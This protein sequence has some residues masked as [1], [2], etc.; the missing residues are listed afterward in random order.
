MQRSLQTETQTYFAFL[1]S[2]YEKIL[3]PHQVARM[4][5]RAQP[6]WADAMAIIQVL[7]AHATK[8][9]GNSSL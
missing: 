1:M 8:M 6:W 5:R 2:D 9:V 7:G 3:T 4:H